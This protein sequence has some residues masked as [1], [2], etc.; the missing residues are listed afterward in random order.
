MPEQAMENKAPIQVRVTDDKLRAYVTLP[1][2]LPGQPPALYSTADIVLALQSKNVVFGVLQEN[3][4]ELSSDPIY[5]REYLVAQGKEVKEGVPGEYE[6]L[7]ST[8]INRKPKI[9]PDGTVDY[10]SIKTIETVAQGDNIA[11]YHPAVQ[12]EDGTA[13]TGRKIPAK[14]VRDLPP[15]AGKGFTR[16]EDGLTYTADYSGKIEKQGERITISPVYEVRETVGVQVGDIDFAGDIIIHGGVSNGVMIQAKGSVT[17]EGT[18]ENC[19]IRAFGDIFLLKGVKGG[20]RTE[21]SAK[22]NITAEYIEYAD[23]YAGGDITADVFFKST[24]R[25]DGRI[26]LSGKRSSVIGGSM[27]AVEGIVCYNVGNE[28]GVKTEVYAGVSKERAQAIEVQK[29][30]VEVL[31]SHLQSIIDGLA[32]FDAIMEKSGNKDAKSDPRRIQLL[33]AKIQEEASLTDEKVKLSG[34]QNIVKRGE[35]AKILIKGVVN[36]G[37]IA[38]VHENIININDVYKAVEFRDT[39]DGVAVEKASNEDLD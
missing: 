12:G 18:V 3:V 22:G 26:N 36:P 28:F 33:R 7:F 17:I 30:K 5:G 14:R 9:L 4:Q 11:V 27:S 23:V 32:K 2:A 10:M 29:Q 38:G 6:Y 25:C 13:V 31:S 15:I 8:T 37:V 19:V 20:D 21:I 39:P 35:T 16:S 34:M 1:R 24:V